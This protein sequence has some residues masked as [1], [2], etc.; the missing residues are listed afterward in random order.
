[1]AGGTLPQESRLS[2]AELQ[3]W[4]ELWPLLSRWFDNLG[5]SSIH[6]SSWFL[7]LCLLLI[8]ALAVGMLLHFQHIQGWLASK[9]A[10]THRLSFNGSLPPG[11]MRVFPCGEGVAVQKRVGAWGMLLFHCGVAVIIA[12]GAL[13]GSNRF[14]AHLEL[15]EG[16]AFDGRPDKLV[17][18]HGAVPTAEEMGF[19]LRLDRLV[20]DIHGEDVRELQAWLSYQQKD[21]PL[22]QGKLEINHPL[23]I[24]KYTLSLDKMLGRTALFERILPDG[25]RRKLQINFLVPRAEWGK[26]KPLEREQAVTLD[27][28][29]VIF[30]MIL[31]S[32]S[33]PFFRLVTLWQGKTTFNGTLKP[34]MAA[35]VGPYRLVFQGDVPWVGLYLASDRAEMAIFAGMILALTGFA[36]HLLFVPRRLSL[37]REGEQWLLQGWARPDDWCFERDWNEWAGYG[38]ASVKQRE[39]TG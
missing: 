39:E 13:S 2:A 18:E 12:A 25:E 30:S 33:Q 6:A 8:L 22:M 4:H 19:R 17:L 34:G 16:E 20:A 11:L 7:M 14:A 23:R 32:G 21:A 26:G 29:S 27:N 31:I 1:M 38:E 5:L 15:A 10:P 37:Q 36:M 35:D 9:A 3:S 28:Q 24:G